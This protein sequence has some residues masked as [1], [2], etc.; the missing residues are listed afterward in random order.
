MNKLD[1]KTLSANQLK[2]LR[3]SL[4][5]Q[6]RHFLFFTKMTA[7]FDGVSLDCIKTEFKRRKLQKLKLGERKTF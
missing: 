2:D 1:V 5:K 6:S 4:L 3:K 7:T